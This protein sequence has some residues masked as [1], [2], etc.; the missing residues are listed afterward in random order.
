MDFLD[1]DDVGVTKSVELRCHDNRLLG[2][3]H[4]LK[5]TTRG[6]IDIEHCRFGR[7]TETTSSEKIIELAH[8]LASIP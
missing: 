6:K 5:S 4:V 1:K 3:L 2:D 8:H 7:G